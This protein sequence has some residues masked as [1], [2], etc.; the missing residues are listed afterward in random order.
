MEADCIPFFQFYWM[1]NRCEFSVPVLCNVTELNLIDVHFP[2]VSNYV[3]NKLA[4]GEMSNIL[5]R[6]S[7]NCVSGRVQ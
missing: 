5:G 3:K 6:F 4:F 7:S 1:H 2:A